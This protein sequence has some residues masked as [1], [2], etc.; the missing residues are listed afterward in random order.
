VGITGV[1]L[2]QTLMGALTCVMV[3]LLS[4]ALF[5]ERTGRIAGL[6]SAVY[7]F[8]IYFTGC[9]LS[10]TLFLLL[11]VTSWYYVVRTWREISRNEPATRWVASCL[12]AGL[13]AALTVLTRASALPVFVLVPLVWLA[14]GP[15]RA[16]GVIASVMMIFVLAVGMSPWVA[17]NY[18]RSGDQKTPG[19]LVITTCKV[20]ES[21]YEAVGP[22]A[23]GGPNKENTQWPMEADYLSHDE[24]ARD[25][26]L[27]ERSLAY[28]RSDPLRTLRLGW[29]KFL[30]TWN[31]IPNYEAGRTP[32]H[33]AVSLASYVPVLLTAIL[34]LFVGAGRARERVWLL[35]PVLVI[36]FLHTV[37]VGS[38]RYRLAA[39]PFVIIL[40]AVG[41]SW[42][43]TKVF[44]RPEETVENN[45]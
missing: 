15:D 44:K 12:V 10:E 42:L 39:M 20:G 9:I 17:R 33:V 41:V 19:R 5:G 26:Y 24:Y 31:V 34:G 7:P 32:F 22:F 30:R 40:S 36:A 35:L 1:R 43:V 21:L 6:I 8:A 13:L 37:F 45:G 29:A 23:T 4:A 16:R 11:F 27:L 38:V 2:I 28:M 18:K 25:R 14:I 3:Y